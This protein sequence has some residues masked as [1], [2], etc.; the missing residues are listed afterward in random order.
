MSAAKDTPDFLE[1]VVGYRAWRLADDGELVPWTV[2]RAGGWVPG[3]NT[4]ACHLSHFMVAMG[5]GAR[6][7]PR[8]RPPSPTCMCGLYAL[9]D[10]TD[11]RIAPGGGSALGAIVAWGDLEVHATGFRAEHA[12]IVALALPWRCSPA[13]RE[14]LELAAARYRVPLVP[15]ERLADTA[16]EHGAP[17]PDYDRLPSRR[18]GVGLGER[19]PWAF[20]APDLAPGGEVGIDFS[21][22]VW[23][24][25]AVDHVVVGVTEPFAALLG[26]DPQQVRVALAVP[27]TELAAGDVLGR[28]TAGSTTYLVWSPVA[29]TVRETSSNAQRLLGAPEGAGW[30]ATVEPADWDAD[31]DGLRWGPEA[32]R[33]YRVDATREQHG[34][35]AF[36]DV[37]AERITALPRVTSWGDVLVELRAAR[38]RPLPRFADTAELYDRLGVDLGCSLHDDPRV[39]ERLGRLD[40]TL[41]LEMRD[42]AARLTLELSRGAPRLRLGTTVAAADLTL[43]CTAEDAHRL[44]RGD[45]DAPAALRCGDLVSTAPDARTLALLSVLKG[46]APGYARRAAPD[47]GPHELA[48]RRL[49]LA[50]G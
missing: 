8:H 35:D 4:A 36:A 5:E 20:P 19:P 3:V 32:R 1:P 34:A 39:A 33:T 22:H 30:L 23:A 46:L 38:A 2:T 50:T 28:V 18:R 26:D 6:R 40:T 7:T 17:L 15:Q 9:H 37:R 45:L 16:H 11:P 12:C 43:S 25:T 24:E 31:R 10:G 29:G 21:A 47:P 27:G 42:P 13:D 44:L 14:R 41:A 48:A 49:G